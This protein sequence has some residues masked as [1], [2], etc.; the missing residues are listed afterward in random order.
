MPRAGKLLGHDGGVQLTTWPSSSSVPTEI[1]FSV[2]LCFLLYKLVYAPKGLLRP[3]RPKAPKTGEPPRAPPFSYVI[4]PPFPLG[5]PRQKG[6]PGRP[7]GRSSPEGTPGE[8]A[9]C[10]GASCNAHQLHGVVIR[11]CTVGGKGPAPAAP[12]DDGPL[13]PFAHPHGHGLH[14]AAAVRRPVPG[15]DVH[16][17]VERQLGQWLW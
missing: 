11:R 7:C 3:L 6:R 5:F 2:H 15:L 9:G 12:V 13:S 1:I 8:R 14:N 4:H 10:P 16:M 17:Q